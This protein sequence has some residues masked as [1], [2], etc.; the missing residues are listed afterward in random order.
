M[1]RDGDTV[2][3]RLTVPEGMTSR[4]VVA[5]LNDA[6]GLDGEVAAL[7]VEGA[8][9]PETYNYAWG[10]SRAELIRR[11]AAAMTAVLDELWAARDPATAAGLAARGGDPRLDRR[12]GDRR[13][14]RAAAGRGGLPQPAAP[15][16]EAAGRPDGRLCASTAAAALGRPLTPG[17]PAAPIALQ[18]LRRRRACRRDRSP[19]P[20]APRWRRCCSPARSD[21]LFFV[22]DGSGGHAFARTLDEHQRNVA[23]WRKL[24]ERDRRRQV[25]AR[26]LPARAGDAT[27]P[28]E[29]AS[30]DDRLDDRLRPQRRTARRLRLDLGGEERQRPRPRRALP[31]ARRAARGW[32]PPSASGWR[33]R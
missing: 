9:L 24:N 18:H 14:G 12:E 30:H 32:R 21:E 31:A 29:D 25:S 22:A 33:R 20:A 4:Q 15:R 1:L 26:R 2:V 3:R 19:I 7:P 8:L 23:R 27:T 10:D 17:R 16:H 5:L 6:D 13:A 28:S 11:M